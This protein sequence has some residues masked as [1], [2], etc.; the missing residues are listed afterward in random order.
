M[1]K[2]AFLLFLMVSLAVLA[3]NLVSACCNPSDP[4]DTPCTGNTYCDIRTKTCVPCPG[5]CLP[6]PLNV[7]TFGDL[8]DSIMNYI[9]YIA[10]VLAPLMAVVGAFMLLTAGGDPAQVNKAKEIF[11]YTGLGLLVVL[12]GRAVVVAIRGALGVSP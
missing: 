10:L 7:C 11:L 5:V 8:V 2:P 3:P 9:F 4:N 1:R 12:L 6:N